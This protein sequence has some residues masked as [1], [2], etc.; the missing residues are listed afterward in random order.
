[1]THNYPAMIADPNTHG[2]EWLSEEVRK[3]LDGDRQYVKV[4]NAVPILKVIDIA[5]FEASFPGVVLASLDGTSIRV[6]C[7]GVTRRMVLLTRAATTLDM[8]EAVLKSLHGVRTGST[9]TTE[10][11]IVFDDDDNEHR[12]PT[13]EDAR[14]FRH[15]L[16][17][18][19]G[20][21]DAAKVLGTKVRK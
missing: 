17:K 2:F 16:R 20:D 12:F 3:D 18:G 8:Q 14:A 21:S 7:Q 6:T 9:R 5:L 4:G 1:M 10:T 19:P 11:F 13:R 15:D